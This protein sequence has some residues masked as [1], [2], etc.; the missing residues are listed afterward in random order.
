M[1][2]FDNYIVPV[3]FGGGALALLGLLLFGWA[4]PSF[5]KG[6][7]SYLIS[8]LGLGLVAFAYF[9]GTIVIT[10]KIWLGLLGVIMIGWG[11]PFNNRKGHR[12]M[13]I[14]WSIMAI[15]VGIAFIFAYGVINRH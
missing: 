5:L 9:D 14:F 12:A 7:W 6:K 4:L 1:N 13:T 11:F 8:L 10:Y 15:V 3:F 2:M